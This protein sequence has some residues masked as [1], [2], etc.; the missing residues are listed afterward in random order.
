MKKRGFTLIE[1]L[2]VIV[3]LAIIALIS[4]PII[5]NILEKSRKEAF[6]DTVYHVIEAIEL[7]AMLNERT[8][9]FSYVVANNEI[10]P[11]VSMSGKINAYG[12]VLID[13]DG[14]AK[15][16]LD[17]GTWCARKG[18]NDSKVMLSSSP[19]TDNPI[20]IGSLMV[21]IK[22]G[23]GLLVTST[24]TSKT[25]TITNYEFK[26]KKDDAI[27]ES[28]SSSENEHLFSF[29]H[30][31]NN[32]QYTIEVEVEDNIGHIAN[33]S[34]S[35]DFSYEPVVTRYVIVEVFEHLDGNGAV[36]NELEF[37]DVNNQKLNYTVENV[38]DS[39]TSGNPFYWTSTSYWSKA[40]L[41]DGKYS[42]TTNGDGGSTS[43][44]FLYN[45]NMTNKW[46]RFLVDFGKAKEIKTIHLW[47]GGNDKRQPKNIKMYQYPLEIN[48]SFDST[49][50]ENR[51]DSLSC[52]YDKNF[53]TVYTTPTKDT[54]YF[55]YPKDTKNPVIN[56]IKVTRN[57]NILQVRADVTDPYYSS[58]MKQYRFALVKDNGNLAFNQVPWGEV[59]K[60]ETMEY[61]LSMLE[62]S[63][64][65]IYVE[66][67]DNASNT[68]YKISKAYQFTKKDVTSRYLIMEVYDHFSSN[69]TVVTEL[70]FYNASDQKIT[71]DIP[72]VYDKARN[73]V[74]FYWTSSAWPKIRLYDG[75]ISYTSNSSG[76]ASS[77]IFN[78]SSSAGQGMWTRALVDFSSIQNL[79]DIKIWLG[80][81][82]GR[83]PKEVHFY[84]S[85]STDV[86]TIYEKNIKVRENDSL[87]EVT[88]FIMS[89]DIKPV[90]MFERKNVMIYT[91]QPK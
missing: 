68:S 10:I 91:F 86:D 8:L 47:T 6:R 85:E 56:D 11:N 2:A 23:E 80:G 63:T 83:T 42:Y 38:Y 71:Y 50:I 14:K 12:E 22:W 74:P 36:I 4:V 89:S 15:V 26:I 52:I 57:L 62:E 88:N 13:S 66:A 37:L 78:Y 72:K 7:D 81:P 35:Y 58:G 44:L 43:T 30:L 54:N 24:A 3:I 18:V 46:A 25:S 67:M 53:T 29:E 17:N 82:E 77:T 61:D 27:V 87:I 51:D 32:E 31:S 34:V 19:C 75:N 70:E 21:E 48:A 9:P 90:T 49:Y 5:L 60:S 41:N 73:G 69:G 76:G 45:S 79:K 55:V 33:T 40:N 28:Y 1:L 20:I 84:V 39:T 65:Y 16:E 64:Y 59:I